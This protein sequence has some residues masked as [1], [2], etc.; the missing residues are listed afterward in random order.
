MKVVAWQEDIDSVEEEIKRRTGGTEK[1]AFPEGFVEEIEKIQDDLEL[2]LNGEL[3]EYTNYD[4]EEIP[5]R[6]FYHYPYIQNVNF[7][8]VKVIGDSA[9]YS[10][11]LETIYSPNL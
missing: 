6:L 8:N 11:S 2:Y 9:F 1:L 4:I 5:E 7:P 10:S 3:K